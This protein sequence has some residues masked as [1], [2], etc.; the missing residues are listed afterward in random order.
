MEGGVC[1]GIFGQAVAAVAMR[2]RGTK[3][4][5]HPGIE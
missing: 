2:R 3:V 5:L 4:G 1:E